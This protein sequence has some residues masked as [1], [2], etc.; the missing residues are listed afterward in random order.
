[1]ELLFLGRGAAFNTSQ[2]NTAAC[3]REGER[4][5]LLDCGETVFSA[6]KERGDFEE[7]LRMLLQL[8][9]ID[10]GPDGVCFIPAGP[11]G[12]AA[13]ERLD[14]VPTRH[15]E[16]MTCYSFVMETA[17]GG[18]FYSADTCTEAPFLDF[19]RTHPAFERAY[20]DATSAEGPGIHLPL[21]RLAAVTPP[22]L[23]SR[24][25]LMHVNDAACLERGRQL[26]FGCAE[27]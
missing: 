7:R 3:I 26:G 20:M 27:V 8:F 19:V 24:V 6:L 13:F 9:G 23:R 22:A 15:A 21:S 1:M 4:L 18:V 14:L 17:G 25:Y 11:L 16:G 2:G 12:F 5:M 10:V